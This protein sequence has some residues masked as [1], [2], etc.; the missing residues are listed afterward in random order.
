MEL[1]KVPPESY[2][3][4]TV[5]RC[6]LGIALIGLVNLAVSFALALWVALRS[7][8]VEPYHAVSL[9]RPLWSNLLKH[10]ARFLYPAKE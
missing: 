5:L 4:M 3:F 9:L 7:R 1:S 2:G 8:D 6:G 10:P